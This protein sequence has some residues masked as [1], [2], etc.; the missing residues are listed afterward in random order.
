MQDAINLGD[1]RNPAIPE[2]SPAL[3]DC[4]DWDK[5][6]VWSH[7]ELDRQVNACARGLAARGL[8]RGSRI[9]IV[10]FNRA[11][12]LIAYFAIMRAGYVAVPTNIKFP[13][14]TIA[15]VFD[16]SAIRFAFCDAAGRAL[17]PKHVPAVDFDSSGSNSF[18]NFLEFGPF[19]T[20]RPAPGEAAMVLYT[21]GST[22]RPKGVPLS[23]EGQLW[24]VRSRV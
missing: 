7:G 11:E 8:A 4:R 12:A 15:F 10:S 3:I 22:G 13:R 9:A 19:E 23:H 20:V 6:V 2:T 18:A 5:P 24:A 1:L 14:E 21:S 17:L 16:D